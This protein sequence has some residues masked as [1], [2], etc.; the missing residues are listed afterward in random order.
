MSN[1]RDEIEKLRAQL[2]DMGKNNN[3][4]NYQAREDRSVKIVDIDPETMFDRIV[5][6]G[7][8][9]RITSNKAV[10]LIADSLKSPSSQ[11]DI[12]KKMDR[13]MRIYLE[14]FEDL[15]YTTVFAALGF[16]KWKENKNFQTPI[17]LIPLKLKR[18]RTGNVEI[19]WNGDDVRVSPTFME[20]MREL[21]MTVP[22]FDTV[23]DVA[24][25]IEILLIMKEAVDERGGLSINRS[26]AV[27]T[28]D[29]SKSAMYNDI[30]PEGWETIPPLVKMILEPSE[31][32][33]AHSERYIPSCTYSI[34]DGDSSQ[35]NVILD[36]LEGRSVVVE[37]PPGTGKSQTIAN[38]IA[39]C[40]GNGKTVLFVS[41]KMAALNVVKRRLDEAE[42]SPYILE[43][44]S[45][46]VN[47][48]NFLRE[49]EMSLSRKTEHEIT[50]D[51]DCS[52][53]ERVRNEL[54]AYAEAIAEPI[55][56]RELT[57]YQLIGMRD[58]ALS[59]IKRRRRTPARIEIKN[60]H[61]IDNEDWDEYMGMLKAAAETIPQVMP[62]KKNYWRDCTVHNLTPDKEHAFRDHL[63]SVS[64]KLDNSVTSMRE[65]CKILDV[66]VPQTIGEMVVLDETCKNILKHGGIS[67]K[68]AVDTDADG[69][70]RAADEVIRS[71][72]EIR[73]IRSGILERYN[74]DI[75]KI[76]AGTMLESFNK[77]SKKMFF[78][79]NKVYKDTM[80]A[81]QSYSIAEFDES[82][83]E[84]DLK[85]IVRY[86]ENIKMFSNTDRKNLFGD[87]WKGADSDPDELRRIRDWTAEVK[88]N[89]GSGKFTDITALVI[90]RGG[91][92]TQFEDRYR[93]MEGNISSMMDSIDKL[94]EL[95]GMA[96]NAK[97][98]AEF[99][100]MKPSG[101]KKWLK[102]VNTNIDSLRPWSNYCDII[103]RFSSSPMN[104]IAVKVAS[105]EIHPLDIVDTFVIGYSSALLGDAVRDRPKL[106][107][108]SYEVQDMLIKDLDEID[109]AV[110]EL[111]SK[112]LHRKLAQISE[113]RIA[114]A[115]D[116]IRVLKGEFNRGH[117]QMSV[118]KIM[119]FAGNAIQAVKPCFMM[120]PMSVAQYLGNKNMTFDVV[121]FDEASQVVPA[122]SLGTLMRGSQAVIM[123]DSKQ[124]P[125][126]KFF[127]RR[128]EGSSDIATAKDMESLLNLCRASLPVR[129]LAWHYRS[130]HDSL[131][132][133]SNRL[134]Y[135][136]RL[137]VCPSPSPAPV[138]MGLQLKYVRTAVYERGTSGINQ[139]EAKMIAREVWHHYTET[140]HK[141]LGVA[142]F[143][144][145]QQKAIME[146]VEKMFRRH[147]DARANMM[148]NSAEPLIIRN[149][150]SIQGDERDV[151]F[152]SIGYGYDSS[153][154][155]SK[156]FGAL[157]RSGGERRLNVLMTRAR[158]RC[159]MFSNFKAMDM[160]ILENVPDGVTALQA[161]LEYAEYGYTSKLDSPPIRDELVDSV[162]S[163]LA[164][165]GVKFT[166]NVGSSDFRIDLAVCSPK[167]PSVYIL[168]I[169]LDSKVYQRMS[170]TRDRDRTYLSMLKRMGWNTYRLWSMDWY[171][172]PD[173]AKKRLWN[174]VSAAIAKIGR[175]ES[176]DPKMF[177]TVSEIVEA[178][179]PICREALYMRVRQKR[180][181]DT[182]TSRMRRNIDEAADAGIVLGRFIE[183][184]GFLIVPD[185]PI[186]PRTR[187]KGER[188]KPEWVHPIEYAKALKDSVSIELTEEEIITDALAFLGLPDRPPYREEA[189]KYFGLD[190]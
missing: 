147:P 105:G 93:N 143:N 80:K 158:E 30:D 95:M 136:D 38:I 98:R 141:S 118:R 20:K 182:V 159:V 11:T 94:T 46:N 79:M 77:A 6:N 189:G 91:A 17:V 59:N 90:S 51:S 148:Q 168:G 176:S 8:G 69:Y 2:L 12:D 116:G 163:F 27:D 178:D 63:A 122:D 180:K 28:F 115:D 99:N 187:P 120:S 164:S 84:N 127:E 74:D 18:D 58:V 160:G 24:S 111:N 22:G 138:N 132:A 130:R 157:N 87:G 39:E 13:L 133:L 48:K 97:F 53:L 23:E 7:E 188:W 81:M 190:Q 171:L 156:S 78:S 186:L 145:N 92:G 73:S 10:K 42:L 21:R 5:M 126:T 150:E 179:A 140:P 181:I 41:E 82:R 137:M 101:L 113:R 70:L 174:K 146:E 55:G 108:F 33:P 72:D 177:E 123:G 165:K 173:G 110:L 134:F 139:K 36:V 103:D 85:E 121:I 25:L 60:P 31:N 112:R 43:L 153:G 124:L 16:L 114:E 71:M 44:H 54:D 64:R 175:D 152:V 144:I 96:E 151:M 66:A 89:I 76:D 172:N 129:V 50:S 117:G 52:R 75:L 15:G 162:G 26:I 104:D 125:P 169:C 107:D 65:I 67:L 119:N 32:Q 49:M 155:L 166:V 40:L 142:T 170:Y 154:K 61:K 57:P 128:E 109:R 62:V 47:R 183:E 3:L 106:R 184:D 45:D 131:M 149:L 167:D 68:D 1:I 161:Y 185:R 29:F 19:H 9:L 100:D 37:G 135:N 4:V 86:Q 88:R 34:L 83:A 56:E 35:M 102:E 14:N